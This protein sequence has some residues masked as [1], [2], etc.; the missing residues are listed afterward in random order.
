[1]IKRVPDNSKTLFWILNAL[2]WAGYAVL[3]WL[4]G[5]AAHDKPM[6]YIGPSLMYAVGGLIITY[7]LRTIYKSAWDRKPVINL[8]ISGLGAI[9]AAAFF[10]G[11]K[12]FA[13]VHFY[14]GFRL[15][16]LPIRQ[17]FTSWELTLS[18][19]VIGTWSG[20]YFGIKYYRMVQQQREQVLKAT[21]TAHQAQLRTLRYQLNPHFLFNTLNAV[22]TLVLESQNE[23]ADQMI[24]RLSAYLRY[25]LDSDPMQKVTLR[26]E[27][28]ALDLYLGL[29]QLRFDDRL[30]INLEIDEPAFRSLVP[31]MI[32][33]P[34]I[35]HSVRHA[36]TVS[37]VGGSI[38][39][40]AKV[41]NDMLCLSVADTGNG[42]P[43]PT[44]AL[45][46]GENSVGLTNTR[47]RL[48]VLYGKHHSFS[49]TNV[50]SHGLKVEMC[51]PLEHND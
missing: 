20:L 21:N 46:Q 15:G 51:I 16:T 22:S 3:N 47:E 43:D 11:F 25:A 12:A 37:E 36:T 42:I 24:S 14:E 49:I 30:E 40:A 26:D 44:S 18:L 13:Y 9:I 4:I 28:D 1:M 33:Q 5:I 35:E 39:I 2:G 41:D 27:I 32:L 45:N 31:S 38:T 7:G 23:T 48:Q 50:Q 19:Y 10:A 34:L 8:L 6:D 17:Y 29:E